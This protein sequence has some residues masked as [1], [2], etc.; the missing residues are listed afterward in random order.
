MSQAADIFK[1]L[2][3]TIVKNFEKSPAGTLS[4]V[5]HTTMYDVSSSFNYITTAACITCRYN[6]INTQQTF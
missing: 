1:D 2:D 6:T 5:W 4:P 3:D